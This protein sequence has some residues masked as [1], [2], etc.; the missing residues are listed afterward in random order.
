MNTKSLRIINTVFFA[1]MIAVN[2]LANL[3]PLGIGTTG[4]VSVKY[5]T[6]F[7][8]A[9]VT[10]A[11]WGVIY[12]LMGVF[13]LYQWGAFDPKGKSEQ[14]V[15][16]IGLSFA[17]GCAMNIGWIFSWH[18]GAI[19]LS[20]LFML[21][22][23]VSLS[24]TVGR[25][26]KNA[27]KGLLR[28]LTQIGFDLYLGWIIAA[29]IANVSVLLVSLGWNRFGLSQSFWTCAVLLAASVIGSLPTLLRSRYFSTAGVA[30]AFIGILIKHFAPIDAG[31]FGGKYFEIISIALFGIV[32]MFCAVIYKVLEKMMEEA[33]KSEVKTGSPLRFHEKSK[34]MKGI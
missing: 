9:P 32:I 20:M 18:F 26:A 5:P 21:G 4:A 34:K 17:V 8:P 23:L 12:L 1:A 28:K 10:F 27:E 3:L 19:P 29:S 2:A 25:M 16:A 15:S 30:W 6:L 31:G 22:L 33:E 7:T 24:F 13:L 11:I 14:T